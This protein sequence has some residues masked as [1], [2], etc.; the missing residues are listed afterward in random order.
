MQID[1][2]RR[3]CQCGRSAGPKLWS[4]RLCAVVSAG[5]GLPR[6]LA[7]NAVVSSKTADPANPLPPSP[8][9]RLLIFLARQHTRRNA[10]AIKLSFCPPPKS[11]WA[12]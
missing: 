10:A 3:A 6:R 12:T 8:P 9:G 11:S 5:I 2:N 4:R 7:A 1:N